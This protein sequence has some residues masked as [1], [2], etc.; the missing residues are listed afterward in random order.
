MNETRDALQEKWPDFPFERFIA[1]DGAG[2]M[3]G[4]VVY[5][6]ADYLE[7]IIRAR[8]AKAWDG[9]YVSGHSNAMRRMSDEPDAP[10]TA[11]PYR[12]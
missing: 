6:V 2:A 3:R 12:L 10:T 9:G 1:S 11:N 4:L 7:P 8:E 5:E